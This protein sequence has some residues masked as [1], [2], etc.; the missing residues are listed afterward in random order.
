MNGLKLPWST[1][2]E[3]GNRY[4]RQIAEKTALP[5]LNAVGQALMGALLRN[6]A[7]SYF[8]RKSA[9]HRDR[10]MGSPNGDWQIRPG[11]DNGDTPWT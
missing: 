9:S 8:R 10:E 6:S 1:G 11:H 2:P 3:E 7:I 5:L 4:Q